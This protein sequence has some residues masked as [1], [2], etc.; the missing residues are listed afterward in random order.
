MRTESKT[1][2][3]LFPFRS[4]LLGKYC[5]VS[6]PPGTEMFHFPGCAS[7]I[8]SRILA[9]HARGF[10]HSEIFG[11]KVA[12]HLPEAYRSYATSFIASQSQGIHRVLLISR[13]EIYESLLCL[14]YF[15][16]L[17]APLRRPKRPLSPACA[18][19]GGVVRECSC[20]KS[21]GRSLLQQ[22]TR[23]PAGSDTGPHLTGTERGF[24][25]LP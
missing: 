9:V 5:L 12:R 13:Q 20:Q 14:D 1:R 4:P 11:S 15:T 3:G 7:W 18:G 16:Y 22:K 19:K 10:P 25:C 23:L 24:L 21:R 2:F 17:P 8:K 6:F